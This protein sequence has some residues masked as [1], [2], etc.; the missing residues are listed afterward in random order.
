M[1]RKT[2]CRELYFSKRSNK[3]LFRKIQ[4]KCFRRK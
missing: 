2:R 4:D 1:Q 3:Q